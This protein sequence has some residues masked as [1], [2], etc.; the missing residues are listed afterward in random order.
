MRVLTSAS[1][2]SW[3]AVILSI[4]RLGIQRRR[5][6]LLPLHKCNS[7]HSVLL[8]DEFALTRNVHRHSKK[9]EANSTDAPFAEQ[10]H[11][12]T[13]P[14]AQEERDRQGKRDSIRRDVDR[15]SSVAR[16]S[17]APGLNSW[18]SNI[19]ACAH[20]LKIAEM[21]QSSMDRSKDFMSRFSCKCELDNFNNGLPS[22]ITFVMM[23]TNGIT[24]STPRD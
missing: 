24:E 3:F 1:I 5:T 19:F 4:N 2:H 13:L 23:M 22:D 11:E 9:G 15:C 17:A 14:P 21:K 10:H 18:V 12:P 20:T 6:T 7:T 8:V 16:K